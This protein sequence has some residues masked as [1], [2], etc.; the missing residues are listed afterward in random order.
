M[1]FQV[2]EIDFDFDDEELTNAERDDIVG[3]TLLTLSL[4]FP[5]MMIVFQNTFM[6]K[7]NKN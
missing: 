5:L 2:T 6:S 7:F 4:I 1:L 3:D